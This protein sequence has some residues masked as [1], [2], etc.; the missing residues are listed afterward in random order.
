[1]NFPEE[2]TLLL[3]ACYPL[4]YIP[5]REEERAEKAIA[6]SIE[7][8]GK[9]NVYIWDFVNGY[10]ENPNNVGFGKRNPLQAL[11]FVTR[12]PNNAGGV[13]ILRDFQRFL[14]D[15]AISR[16]LRNLARVL[17]SQPKNIIIIAPQ[18]QIPEELTEVIT[19]VDFALPSSPEIKTEIERL[20]SST[21]QSLSEQLLDE[22]VRAAQGLSLERIRRVLTRAIRL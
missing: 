7:K 6:D 14:E 19:V 15:V 20:I 2:F 8:L 1:M 17:K 13:F 22:I 9:R 12:M 18:V 11:E 10:Q 4:I 3:R 5:T 21:G 16:E